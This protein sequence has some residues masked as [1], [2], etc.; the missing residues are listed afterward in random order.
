[1]SSRAGSCGCRIDEGR[2]IAREVSLLVIL[3]TSVLSAATADAAHANLQAVT[4]TGSSAW[5]G[6]FPFTIRGVL[7]CDPEEMLDYTPDSIPWDNGANAGKMGGEWQI[8]FQAVAPGDRGGTT[9]WMGQNYGNQPWIHD[10]SLSYSN[11][12]WVAEINR[13]NSD[14]A[15]GHAPET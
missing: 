10:S 13:L 14:P 12:A 6:T 5:T 15:S 8:T 4:R 2:E 7:L 1:M 11:E 9:C 3:G